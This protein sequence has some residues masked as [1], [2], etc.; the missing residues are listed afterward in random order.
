MYIYGV[1]HTTLSLDY[2]NNTFDKK[3]MIITVPAKVHDTTWWKLSMHNI[4]SHL[5]HSLNCLESETPEKSL[6]I[7]ANSRKKTWRAVDMVDE[8]L[9]Q[10]HGKYDHVDTCNYIRILEIRR[11]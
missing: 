10:D 9:E 6:Y 1:I 11:A 8:S 5:K 3:M 7:G 4:Y 2:S